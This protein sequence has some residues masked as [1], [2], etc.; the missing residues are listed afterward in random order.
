M[1]SDNKEMHTGD[2]RFS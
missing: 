1:K 2:L